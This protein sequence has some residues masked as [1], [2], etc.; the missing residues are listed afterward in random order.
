MLSTEVKPTTMFNMICI[1]SSPTVSYKTRKCHLEPI[2]HPKSLIHIY[3]IVI[4]EPF[5]SDDNSNDYLCS[6]IYQPLT[7]ALYEMTKAKPD[8]PLKWLAHFMLEHNKNKPSIQDATRQRL[9][10]IHTMKTKELEEIESKQK[11]EHNQRPAKCGC[12]LSRAISGASITNSSCC[13]K[14]H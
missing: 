11:A 7:D 5:L 13:S 12:I 1:F 8:D 10:S 9:Q 4:L 2:S 6:V 3:Y 14:F